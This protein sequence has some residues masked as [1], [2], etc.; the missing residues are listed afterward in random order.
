[1]EKFY[2]FLHKKSFHSEDLEECLTTM[3][4][5]CSG[6]HDNPRDL[7]VLGLAYMV[8]NEP[9]KALKILEECQIDYLY[10]T[11]ANQAVAGV[12]LDANNRTT[13]SRH[14]L[15][16]LDPSRLIPPERQLLS[17]ISTPFLFKNSP[18]FQE[19]IQN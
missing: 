2:F 17:R 6:N 7:L 18:F 15:K 12:I 16:D 8:N 4:Q 1:M 9:A 14:F 13:D 19:I 10:K 11:P 5:V 3:E